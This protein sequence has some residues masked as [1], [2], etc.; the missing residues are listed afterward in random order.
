VAMMSRLLMMIGSF[1]K[2]PYERDDNLQKRPIQKCAM[3]HGINIKRSVQ[4][5]VACC[6]VLQCVAVCCSVLQ[7]VAVCYHESWHQYQE[8]ATFVLLF[9]V[10]LQNTATHC[11]TLQHTATCCNMLQ[12]AATCCNTLQHTATRCSQ[13]PCLALYRQIQVEDSTLQHTA[14]RCNTLHYTAIHCNT[15]QSAT[16]VL[17]SIEKYKWRTAHC[18]TLHHTAPHC[19]TL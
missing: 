16:F 4:C 2:E 15:V 5:V 10:T 13:N 18:N 8:S 9:I 7:C 1:A 12:H 11:N 3:N 19:T 17:L 14:T 6:S